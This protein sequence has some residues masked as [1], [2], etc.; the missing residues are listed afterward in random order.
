MAET[1]CNL[2]DYRVDWSREEIRGYIKEAL[3]PASRDGMAY[4]WGIAASTGHTCSEG[5][6]LLTTVIL[7]SAQRV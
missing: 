7:D 5:I 4:R 2:I 1:N 3:G 6:R